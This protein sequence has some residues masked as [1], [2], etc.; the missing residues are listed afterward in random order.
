MYVAIVLNL[1]I[2]KE[3]YRL[4]AITIVFVFTGLSLAFLSWQEN[5]LDAF[6]YCEFNDVRF[7]VDEEIPGYQTGSFCICAQGGIVECLPLETQA[8]EVDISKQ[9][10]ETDGLEFEYSY[11][12]GMGENNGEVIFNTTFT[13]VSLSDD[14]LII[15]LEQMQICPEANVVSE[16]EG[17]Y[18]NIDG[19]IKL[20]NL[21]EPG[22]GIDCVVELKYTLED[23]SDFYSEKTQILFVDQEG[24][25][26]QASICLYGGIIYNDEDIFKGEEGMICICENNEIICDEELSD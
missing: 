1:W 22:E 17:F 10:V 12:T 4:I 14:D 19:T 16:Q 11:L 26:V 13:D 18:E 21:V 15:T 20:Y 24:F 9:E 25:E 5:D 23:F 6:A 3:S 7:S 8:N 2:M